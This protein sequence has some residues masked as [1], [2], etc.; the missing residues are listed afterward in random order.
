MASGRVMRQSA[1]R[2]LHVP[3]LVRLLN[4]AFRAAFATGF[5]G[6]YRPMVS[7]TS[8][9]R[10]WSARTSRSTSCACSSSGPRLWNWA[11]AATGPPSSISTA[12]ASTMA[13]W[14]VS[15]ESELV[16]RGGRPGIDPDTDLLLG[17]LERHRRAGV[18]QLG[19]AGTRVLPDHRR[20]FAASSQHPVG[21]PQSQRREGHASFRQRHRPEA[22]ESPEDQTVD[23]AF[24]HL[25]PELEDVGRAIEHEPVLDPLPRRVVQE[26]QIEGAHRVHREGKLLEEL[27]HDLVPERTVSPLGAWVTPNDRVASQEAL[28]RGAP[29]LE[30]F[31]SQRR[32]PRRHRHPT[33]TN[34]DESGPARPPEREREHGE[35][36]GAVGPEG[37]VPDLL[38]DLVA[39]VEEFDERS[40]VLEREMA[41]LVQLPSA[42]DVPSKRHEPSEGLRRARRALQLPLVGDLDRRE[43]SRLRLRRCQGR[44]SRL[45]RP[46]VE[47]LDPPV[48]SFGLQDVEALRVHLGD[49]RLGHAEV[50][51]V[52][53]GRREVR[54]EVAQLVEEVG[55]RVPGESVR[56][57]EEAEEVVDLRHHPEDV[58]LVYGY[59]SGE[60][61]EKKILEFGAGPVEDSAVRVAPFVL[62]HRRGDEAVGVL[63]GRSIGVDQLVAGGVEGLLVI[64]SEPR[65]HCHLRSG[66][67]ATG[68]GRLDDHRRYCLTG[69][70]RGSL[71]PRRHGNLKSPLTCA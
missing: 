28:Q 24:H 31:P 35:F 48:N 66:P 3:R 68:W 53:H 60:M 44:V 8:E 5:D 29:V 62:E 11:V 12:M 50:G 46:G 39:H 30:R 33:V 1:R 65:S 43:G 49:Q 36:G 27:D 14:S 59:L 2:S 69:G 40:S 61:P 18:E 16:C 20:G 38:V 67:S 32:T 25:P 42:P 41:L 21:R 26:L 15:G 63:C 55:E 6:W 4:A 22:G 71:P 17:G 51:R 45:K 13:V 52:L 10:A 19:G 34:L 70:S 57:L 7:R 64:W 54:A 23:V 37:L 47:L 56:S 58:L 9:V